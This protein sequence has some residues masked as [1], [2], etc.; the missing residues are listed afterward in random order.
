M[1]FRTRQC[2]AQADMDYYRDR[3]DNLRR[4]LDAQRDREERERQ[5]RVRERRAEIEDRARENATW[6]QALRENARSFAREDRDLVRA[7]EDY[8]ADCREH[9]KE[10]EQPYLYDGYFGTQAAGCRR[11][12]ELW[13]T[14][15]AAARPEIERLEA[16]IERLKD[17]VR[18]TV[19]A[20]VEAENPEW[21]QVA[22]A[23][24]DGTPGEFL[25]W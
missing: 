14:A 21:R 19:A 24:R 13:T 18:E 17:G 15:E 10:P 11:A 23:M 22:Q 6:P 4:Q 9:G 5:E 20:A 8:I 1:S 16:E 7:D 25:E 2:P 12:L 3:A